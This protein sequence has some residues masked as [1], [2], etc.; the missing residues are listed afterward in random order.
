M[1]QI[2]YKFLAGNKNKSDFYYIFIL[3]LYLKAVIAP[4]RNNAISGCLSLN[5]PKLPI[6]YSM[7]MLSIINPMPIDLVLFLKINMDMV[8][9]M[10][11]A[12]TDSDSP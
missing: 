5:R 7:T 2:E 12:N 6:E 11:I 4:T 9:K 3:V 8:A 10:L 1:L